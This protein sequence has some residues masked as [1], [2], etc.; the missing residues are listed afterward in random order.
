MKIF[1]SLVFVLCCTCFSAFADPLINAWTNPVSG[2]W[3]DLKWSLGVRP[4]PAQTIMLTNQGWKAIAINPSTA[5][6]FPQ[7]FDVSSLI[8]R[9]YTDS[10]HL[11]LLNYAGFQVPLTR[12]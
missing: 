2:N 4:G 11:L 9:G 8:L 12:S 5:Q 1:H 7:T 3:E 10:F 6:N